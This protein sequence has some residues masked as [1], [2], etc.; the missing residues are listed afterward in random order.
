MTTLDSFVVGRKKRLTHDATTRRM[1]YDLV[2]KEVA[3]VVATVTNVTAKKNDTSAADPYFNATADLPKGFFGKDYIAKIDVEGH[4]IPVLEG[5]PELLSNKAVRPRM[6]LSEVWR[7]RNITR[8][9]EVMIDGAGY[10]G[11]VPLSSRWL[12]SVADAAEYHR[13]MKDDMDTI[14]WVEPEYATLLCRS[15]ALSYP[16]AAEV[17]R[18]QA[19]AKELQANR[20]NSSALSDGG[21]GAGGSPGTSLE[22]A[23]IRLAAAA[24]A[25]A[26]EGTAQKGDSGNDQDAPAATVSPPPATTAHAAAGDADTDGGAADNAAA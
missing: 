24:T 6:W 20:T 2:R 19:I 3:A 9:A 21:A 14:I 1:M 5:A 25:T 17:Q 11:L 12:M 4:E 23:A 10:V 26:A 8:Y 22:A 16:K 7:S 13:T 15:H 18:L